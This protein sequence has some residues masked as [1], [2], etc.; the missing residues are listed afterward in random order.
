[1]I[2]GRDRGR[3]H[4]CDFGGRGHGFV[5]GGCGSYGRVSLRKA[6]DNVGIVDIATTSPQSIGRNLDILSGHNFLILV[7]L[8]RVVLLRVFH[9]LF[10]ALPRL[11]YHRRSMIDSDS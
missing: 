2:S 5:G 7:L 11:Y 1:M 10:L 6:P 8:P 9:L 4:G 3:G